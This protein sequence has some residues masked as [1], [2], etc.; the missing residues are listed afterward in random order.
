MNKILIIIVSRDINNTHRHALL[1]IKNNLIDS[2]KND[3]NIVDL[4]SVLSE[5]NYDMSYKSILGNFKY[6]FICTDPQLRKVCYIFE[7]IKYDDYDWYIKVRPEIYLLEKITNK[8]FEFFSKEKINSRCRCYEGEKI[9]LSNGLSIPYSSKW[10]NYNSKFT[11]INP[12]DQMYFFHKNI[13]G[14][15][16]APLS[17]DSYLDYV[18]NL[19][20]QIN[21]PFWMESWM[22]SDNYF[23]NNKDNERE[24]HHKFIWNNRNIFINPISL[25]LQMTSLRSGNLILN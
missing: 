18:E 7:K 15:A 25:N 3:D 14:L 24:G 21:K 1:T 22:L 17:L 11:I 9:N 12:D 19:K 20:I 2:L 13:A 16:F 10:I 5:T 8:N 23:I 6:E 4:C